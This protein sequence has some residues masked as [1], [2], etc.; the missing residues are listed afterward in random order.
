[1]EDVVMRTVVSFEKAE[2][3]A[4]QQIAKIA[5]RASTLPSVVT[6]ES[7]GDKAIAKVYCGDLIVAVKGTVIDGNGLSIMCP[8]KIFAREPFSDIA[9]STKE[10]G[11]TDKIIIQTQRKRIET[12]TSYC[13]VPDDPTFSET[14]WEV[15][16][17]AEV[18]LKA[19]KTVS[20]FTDGNSHSSIKYVYMEPLGRDL[21]RL[22][23]TD[24]RRLVEARI[25]V[26]LVTQ[27]ARKNVLVSAGS[28]YDLCKAGKSL[29]RIS[30]VAGVIEGR[31]KYGVFAKWPNGCVYMD[32]SYTTAIF[33]DWKKVA[34]GP[35]GG[36]MVKFQREKL[37]PF[38]PKRVS[39]KESTVLKL[40]ID[41][42]TQVMTCVL[43]DMDEHSE[44]GIKVATNTEISI[45]FNPGYIRSILDLFAKGD[46]TARFSKEKP[47]E[48]SVL[49]TGVPQ[50]WAQYIRAVVMPLQGE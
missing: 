9:V 15:N 40:N 38:L 21:L 23:A 22:V 30:L 37:R 6:L 19:L 10:G 24:G 8:P 32:G 36:N 39:Y 27:K 17:P 11:P 44:W 28:I 50:P 20:D 25:A 5:A 46:V 47:R 31:D 18:L 35:H 7:Q 29:D 48:S 41:P 33:P 26:T 4:L 45:W 1:L 13:D 49:L 2:A 34:Y 12:D 3:K 42:T 16:A 43:Q 14:F